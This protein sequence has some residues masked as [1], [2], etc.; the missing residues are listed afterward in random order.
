MKKIKITTVEEAKGRLHKHEAF[1]VRG[2]M[3]SFMAGYMGDG[4]MVRTK[5][6]GP[7]VELLEDYN[8]DSYTITKLD[9]NTHEF[10]EFYE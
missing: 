3:S 9:G 2:P 1:W 7:V 5:W 6:G 4:L 8:K 10:V